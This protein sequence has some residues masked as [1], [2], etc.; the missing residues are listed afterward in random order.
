MLAINNNGKYNKNQGN[1]QKSACTITF[2]A[3][4]LRSGQKFVIPVKIKYR[5]AGY[6]HLRFHAIKCIKTFE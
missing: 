5:S 4:G 2:S 3:T 6:L 1:N